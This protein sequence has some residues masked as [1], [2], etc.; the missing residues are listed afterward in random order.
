[1]F[2]RIT[3]IE[4]ILENELYEDE[5]HEMELIE[6]LAELYKQYAFIEDWDSILED[7]V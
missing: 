4:A 6:E 7:K 1:M 3:E 5:E 2:L